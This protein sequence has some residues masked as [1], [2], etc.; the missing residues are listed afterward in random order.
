MNLCHESR[1][2]HADVVIINIERVR[3]EPD[4]YVETIIAA[5]REQY[6]NIPNDNLE[7]DT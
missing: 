3:L 6:S 4:R 7:L 5:L 1:T 2:I